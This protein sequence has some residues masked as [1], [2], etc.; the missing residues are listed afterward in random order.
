MRSKTIA[1][2]ST[3]RTSDRLALPG[4]LVLIPENLNH[5][6]RYRVIGTLRR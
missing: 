5:L 4:A 2:V 3:L 6:A 1:A